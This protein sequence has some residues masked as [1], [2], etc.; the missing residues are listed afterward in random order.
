MILICFINTWQGALQKRSES[1]QRVV[2]SESRSPT[3]L[4]KSDRL[5]RSDKAMRKEIWAPKSGETVGRP[6][7]DGDLCENKNLP[8][9]SEF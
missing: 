9:F 7:R 2:R 3:I 8:S 5:W 1:P 6:H 4:T